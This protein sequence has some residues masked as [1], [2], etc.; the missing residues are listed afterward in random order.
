MRQTHRSCLVMLGDAAGSCACQ[1]ARGIRAS[2]VMCLGRQAGALL[3]GLSS[4]RQGLWTSRKQ[5]GKSLQQ[6]ELWAPG[7]VSRRAAGGFI[8]GSSGLRR[9]W[10]DWEG[11]G[12]VRRGPCGGAAARVTELLR[13]LLGRKTENPVK[14]EVFENLG[15][16]PLLRTFSAQKRAVTKN[17]AVTKTGDI[18]K[19]FSRMKNLAVLRQKPKILRSQEAVLPC[20]RAP[21]PK[22]APKQES[23]QCVGGRNTKRQWPTFFDNSFRCADEAAAARADGCNV[24]NGP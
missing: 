21:K 15:T 19:T 16:W 10:Q 24:F 4:D 8:S 2:R 3:E 13:A 5:G 14:N 22:A 23:E 6:E 12:R 17:G 11:T 20:P 18:G 1:C 7:Q 9:A